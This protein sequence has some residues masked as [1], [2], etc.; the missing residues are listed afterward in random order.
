VA[1][2]DENGDGLVGLGDLGAFQQS[3]VTQTHPEAGDLN[4]D[5][6]INLAD[7]AFFQRHFTAL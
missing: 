7:L 2:P 4:L 6:M 3:F 5:G 1:S